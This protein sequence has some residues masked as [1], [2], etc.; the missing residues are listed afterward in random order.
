MAFS[1]LL[2]SSSLNGEYFEK[3]N[4]K[5][6]QN[7]TIVTSDSYESCN[8]YGKQRMHSTDKSVHRWQFKIRG[9]GGSGFI[10]IG[11]AE[12]TENTMDG[13]T[14]IDYGQGYAIDSDG[15]KYS[16]TGLDHNYYNLN[17]TFKQGD[18]IHM[19]L[20]LS[21]KRLSFQIN[22]NQEIVIENIKTNQAIKYKMAVGLY[23]GDSVELLEYSKEA[24][25]ENDD[26]KEQ[27]ENMVK[28]V[29]QV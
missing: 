15:N 22:D 4:A 6:T 25:N 19:I 18:T 2:A 13:Y 10:Y 3:T 14:F 27:S 29:T 28:Q 7:K 5:L 23:H 8:A 16:P 1:S 17:Q 12:E 21:T 24:N 20:N 9:I 26:E 11:I